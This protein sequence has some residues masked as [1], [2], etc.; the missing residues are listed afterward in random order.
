MS[1]GQRDYARGRIPFLGTVH[2]FA[3]S[4]TEPDGRLLI[5]SDAPEAVAFDFS[6]PSD[7]RLLYAR[8]V[9]L[10]GGQVKVR[11][12]MWHVNQ[13]TTGGQPV[14]ANFYLVL[15]LLGATSGAGVSHHFA[16]VGIGPVGGVPGTGLCLARAMLARTVDTPG[17]HSDVLPDGEIIIG[18]HTVPSGQ[19]LGALHEFDLALP[20]QQNVH[21]RTV[22]NNNSAAGVGNPS[23]PLLDPGIHIRGSW[24]EN[25]LKS[26]LAVRTAIPDYDA[27]PDLAQEKEWLICK[28]HAVDQAQFHKE[29]TDIN[30]TA[31]GNTGLFGVYCVYH[32]YSTNSHPTKTGF[33][34]AHL[35]A[36]DTRPDRSDPVAPAYFGACSCLTGADITNGVLPIRFSTAGGTDN[37]VPLEVFSV[38]P[39]ATVQRTYCVTNAGGATMPVG[40][41]YRPTNIP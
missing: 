20:E 11:L 32:V 4:V 3:A 21:I 24:V 2:E 7:A 1:C 13:V 38:P 27:N 14:S 22:V 39:G 15:R 33:V 8:Q 19:H 25:G 6:S 29:P 18:Y 9:S 30:G 37:S 12:F 23:T 17:E 40:L 31:D 36:R 28:R 41:R 16:E 34:E 10:P 26:N 5:V 35:H